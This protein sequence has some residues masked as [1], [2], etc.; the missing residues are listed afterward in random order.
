MAR[1]RYV[2]SVDVN[3]NSVRKIGRAYYLDGQRG[4]GV[5]LT[6]TLTSLKDDAVFELSSEHDV[7]VRGHIHLMGDGADLMVQ[8]DKW[9]YWEGF[10]RVDGDLT[11]RGG[12]EINSAD[13][14]GFGV[15]DS[16]INIQ[17]TLRRITG[18]AGSKIDLQGSHDVDVFGAIVFG[19][20]I[21]VIKIN[22]VGQ[23]RIG[24]ITLNEAGNPVETGGILRARDAISITV[25]STGGDA[26]VTGL[27]IAG[28]TVDR[29]YD[30][31]GQNLGRQ[32]THADGDSAVSITATG[33]IDVGQSITA[34]K[35]IELNGG[36][37]AHGEGIGIGS[38]VE[39]STSAD[40][41]R[42]ELTAVDAEIVGTV[43]AGG[44]LNT[45]SDTVWTGR[46]SAIEMDLSGDLVVGGTGVDENGNLIDRGGNLQSS[47]SIE[48][49]ARHVSINSLSRLMTD[50][51]GD[52]SLDTTD[53][54]ASAVYFQ[55]TGNLKI[56]GT[57][58]TIDEGSSITLDADGQVW[59]NGI[60]QAEDVLTVI[61][62]THSSTIGV[63]VD[64]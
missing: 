58:V 26:C 12:V 36:G 64:P 5:L 32:I 55:T 2:V 51:S 41:S 20:T 61:A 54:D 49:A 56:K 6:G 44:S 28:G 46:N 23:A 21:G 3:D 14:D 62:G 1:V 37:D 24:G 30:T 48:I 59:I 13:L 34:G 63:L 40:D 8:S 39:V 7:I 33:R 17:T 50:L 42:I 43:S 4:F 22:A 52:G 19:E 35:R 9:I 47:Q 16:S 10:A 31:A 45:D 57:V 38:G 15:N 11:M 53:R 18:A 29:V 60:V 27:W 25:R